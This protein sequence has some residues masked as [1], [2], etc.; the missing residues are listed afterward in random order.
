VVG[1]G[2]VVVAVAGGYGTLSE[3]ALALGAGTPVVG[4]GTWELARPDG[5]DVGI[6][7]VDDPARAVARALE[8]ARARRRRRGRGRRAPGSGAG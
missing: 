5:T 3:I 8:L 1:A 6:E 2:D 4:I 7:R